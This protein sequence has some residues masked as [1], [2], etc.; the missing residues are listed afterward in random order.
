MTTLFILAAL[1]LTVLYLAKIRPYVVTTGSME[2]AIPVHSVCFVNENTPLS[3][4]AA[5]EVIAFRMEGGMLVTH[6]VTAVS[7]GKYTT[8]GDANN[9]EDGPSV[10]AE[11]Y[12][13]KTVFVIPK[14]GTVMIFLHSSAGKILAA[15]V[16]VLLLA[17]SFIPQKKKPA[18]QSEPT[19]SEGKEQADEH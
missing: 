10:T 8:K 16:I 5:G 3:S 18:A 12:I 4:I 19:E 6:R 11:N 1:T 9:T 15:A 13:G 17:A 7:G 14:L 2:P